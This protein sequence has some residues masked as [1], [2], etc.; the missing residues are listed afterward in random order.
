MRVRDFIILLIFTFTTALHSCVTDVE[1]PTPPPAPDWN[2]PSEAGAI[3]PE[4]VRAVEGEDGIRLEWQPFSDNDINEVRIFRA[5]SAA[6]DFDR[7]GV[8]TEQ[9]NLLENFYEDFSAPLDTIVYYYLRAMD[10]SDNRSKI[11]ETLR[12]NLLQK[13]NLSEFEEPPPATPKFT[14]FIEPPG[15][16][17]LFYQ[18]ELTDAS[19]N[20][21]QISHL[22]Q[23]TGYGW[24]EQ[25]EW[26][27]SDSL[28]PGAQYFWRVYAFG[29]LD[30]LNRPH[31]MSISNW[32]GF[33]VRE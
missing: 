29:L 12:F 33:E 32:R 27:F 21:V 31:A 6:V 5:D 4:G 9:N 30:S 19:K 7:I 25:E 8:V 20:T 16:N 3:P 18:I 23:R 10:K 22:I 1:D 17:T 14:W 26:S 13:P 24:R 28:T 15:S 2:Y 11:S